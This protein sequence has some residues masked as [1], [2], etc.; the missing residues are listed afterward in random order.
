MVTTAEVEKEE[1][2]L[3]ETLHLVALHEEKYKE[4]GMK[5]PPLDLHSD[6]MSKEMYEKLLSLCKRQP[7]DMIE[8]HWTQ[9]SSSTVRMQSGAKSTEEITEP[10]V[11]GLKEKGRVMHDKLHKEH[12]DR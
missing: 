10:N 3:W 1:R 7:N 2:V 9:T 8:C 4:E 5:V 12:H 6:R 11:F